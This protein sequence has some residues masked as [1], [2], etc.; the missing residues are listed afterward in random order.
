[1][2]GRIKPGAAT[3]PPC[4]ECI[5]VKSGKFCFDF[6]LLHG[7]SST[8]ATV[9]GLLLPCAFAI[10]GD[11][12]HFIGLFMPKPYCQWNMLMASIYPAQNISDKKLKLLYSHNLHILRQKNYRVLIYKLLAALVFGQ[13]IPVFYM[14]SKINRLPSPPTKMLFH[15]RKDVGVGVLTLLAPRLP[16]HTVFINQKATFSVRY[17]FIFADE[18]R[19]QVIEGGK[20]HLFFFY[21]LIWYL[22]AV[23]TCLQGLCR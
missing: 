8:L 15:R 22:P 4:S 11:S 21:T 2:Q 23:P 12:V 17:I 19:C 9:C 18:Q 13:E 16:C 10:Q 20:N 14:V 7:L 1:M 6:D 3:K 5:S